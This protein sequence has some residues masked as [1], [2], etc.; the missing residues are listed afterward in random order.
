[1]HEQ[2]PA[3]A[4]P[5]PANSGPLFV[6]RRAFLK[7]ASLETPGIYDVLQLTQPMHTDVN[8]GVS[9]NGLQEGFFEVVVRATVTLRKEAGNPGALAVLEVDQAGVFELRNVDEQQKID[10]LEIGAPSILTGYLRA[11]VTDLLTRA[12]LPPFYLPEINWVAIRE[13]VRAAQAATAAHEDPAHAAAH[14]RTPW[15]H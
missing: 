13:Q 3:D 11:A 4:H 9:I 14:A 12:T 8:L 1:M 2:H 7:G 6:L 15:V 5:T 10:A